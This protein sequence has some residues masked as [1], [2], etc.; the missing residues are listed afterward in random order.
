MKPRLLYIVTED[1]AVLLHRLP[2]S[3]AARAAGYEVHVATNVTDGAA[4]IAAEEFVLHPVRF[5]AR[6]ALTGRGM[7]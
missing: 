4:A 5:F 3:R 6:P 1:C 7:A 2:M